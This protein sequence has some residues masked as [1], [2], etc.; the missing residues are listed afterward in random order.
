MEKYYDKVGR[1]RDE[2]DKKVEYDSDGEAKNDPELEKKLAKARSE[3]DA[4][5]SAELIQVQKVR[6]KTTV[7]LTSLSLMGQW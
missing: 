4:R 2:H 3:R 7:I 1:I 6:V 5:L